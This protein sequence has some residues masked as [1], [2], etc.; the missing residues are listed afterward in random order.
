MWVAIDHG[1][2]LN[3]FEVA[4]VLPSCS[5]HQNLC[6][7]CAR[8]RRAE[9]H[10]RQG[11]GMTGARGSVPHMW[12]QTPF[13]RCLGAFLRCFWQLTC[14]VKLR[15]RRLHL[16]GDPRAARREGFPF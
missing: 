10:Q 12:K 16:P 14:G 5:G 6:T 9:S 13:E 2:L 8:S 4:K 15:R 11:Q 1:F 3:G 7:L